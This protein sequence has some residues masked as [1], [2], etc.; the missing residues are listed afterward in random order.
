VIVKRRKRF[1]LINQHIGHAFQRRHQS[2]QR[3][4]HHQHDPSSGSGNHWGIAA[5]LQRISEPLFGVQQHGFPM[6]R[7]SGPTRLRECRRRGAH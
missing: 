6:Q 5:K 2:A 3:F 4:W 1:I 7:L